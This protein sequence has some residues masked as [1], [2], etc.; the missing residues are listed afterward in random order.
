MYTADVY[1]SQN[2][3]RMIMTYLFGICR[4]IISWRVEKVADAI[5][6]MLITRL[7]MPVAPVQCEELKMEFIC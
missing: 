7:L 5:G 2:I 4:D 6:H 3:V 1:G